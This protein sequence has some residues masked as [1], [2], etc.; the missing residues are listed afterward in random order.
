[1]DF[2]QSIPFI[3]RGFGGKNLSFFRGTQSTRDELYGFEVLLCNLKVWLFIVSQWFGYL[4]ITHHDD[5][6][7]VTFLDE[8]LALGIDGHPMGFHLRSPHIILTLLEHGIFPEGVSLGV[9]VV[10]RHC[11]L[12]FLGIGL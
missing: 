7:F 5:N 3:F 9:V 2:F 8:F 12:F 11:N 10:G 1:M 6:F 4:L